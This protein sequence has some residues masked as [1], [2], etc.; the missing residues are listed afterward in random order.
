MKNFTKTQIYLAIKPTKSMLT[1]SLA[2]TENNGTGKEIVKM[3]YRIVNASRY[4]K[5]TKERKQNLRGAIDKFIVMLKE[6]RKQI[7]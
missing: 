6:T 7:K 1:Y 5:M 3:S 2:T 4:K